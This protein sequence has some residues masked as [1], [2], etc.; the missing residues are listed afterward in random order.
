MIQEGCTSN[1]MA[2]KIERLSKT[3]D[4]HDVLFTSQ[5]TK[6]KHKDANIPLANVL[7]RR[8]PDSIGSTVSLL[9]SYCCN[10]NTPS[11]NC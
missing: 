6:G 5:E 7:P 2:T 1:K 3:F 8:H 10:E 9:M 11:I 4:I